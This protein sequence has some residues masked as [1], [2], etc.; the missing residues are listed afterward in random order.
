VRLLLLQL[1]EID[2]AIFRQH[3][4]ALGSRRPAVLGRGG[5]MM[6]RRRA[7]GVIRG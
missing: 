3:G 1:V 7:A 4:W 6:L 5:W 2:D